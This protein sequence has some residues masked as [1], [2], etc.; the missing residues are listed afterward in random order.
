MSV[1]H[2]TGPERLAQ[3]RGL[4]LLAFFGDFSEVSRR[5]RPRFDAFCAAHPELTVF[6]VD[7][8]AVRTVHPRFGVGAVPTVLRLEDGQPTRMLVGE[9]SVAD[10][11]Q[12]LDEAPAPASGAPVKASP[13]VMVFTTP[14]CVWCTKVKSYLTGRGVRFLE[15]DVAKDE[16]A[17]KQMV[18]RSGQMGVPQLDIDG[19]MIVGFDKPRIDQLLGLPPGAP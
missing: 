17:M 1:E 9:C 14:S 7:V 3:H 11:R 4:A 10:Y 2:L 8:G 19:K 6:L 18:E 16:K 13:R 15:V 5:T 12:L